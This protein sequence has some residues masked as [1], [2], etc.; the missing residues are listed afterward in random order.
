M[1][2]AKIIFLYLV[3]VLFISQTT[4]ASETS[5]N[6]KKLPRGL[7][8]V[9]W[10][11]IKRQIN[12][13][14]SIMSTNFQQQAYIKASNTGDIDLFG[15]SVALSGDTLVVGAHGE[16][17]I[18]FEVGGEETNNLAS[19]SGAAFVFVRDINGEWSKQAYLKS[20]NSEENDNF[21]NSVSISGDT[22]VIG[23]WG[24]DSNSTVI[25]SGKDDNSKSNSGAAYVFTRTGS[26]W[27][28]QAYLKAANAD[29][30]DRFGYSVA[31]S[32]DSIVVG[33]RLED[34]IATGI[35]NINAIDNSASNAGAAYV[36][37]R[38]GSIWT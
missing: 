33:A 7:S 23:A 21:A 34:S 37:T 36:F 25:N 18:T 38:T 24:E 5:L 26:T 3:L 16:D 20:Y 29:E 31:I 35:N 17:S 30:N 14:V 2:I 13:P 19:L 1:K 12:I 22:I 9:E 28:Q 11:Q 32:G 15:H 6:T 10:S 27:T 4:V 8:S